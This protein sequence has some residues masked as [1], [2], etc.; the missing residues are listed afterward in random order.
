MGSDFTESASWIDAEIDGAGFGDA[1]LGK[2]LRKLMSQLDS[3]LGQPIPL[4]CEDWANTKAAYRFLANGSV[5][6][7]PILAGHFQATARRASASDGLIPVLQDTSEFVY[8]RA[9]PESR[10]HV[11]P[12]SIM[13]CSI[14]PDFR[15]FAF[16]SML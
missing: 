3:A 10:N 6:E 2:R 14:C 11:F 16:Q 12:V 9:S 8:Q 1:R 4:A 7:D 5:N 15:E 13:S